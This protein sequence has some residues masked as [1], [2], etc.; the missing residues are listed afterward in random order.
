[1]SPYR[2]KI[3]KIGSLLNFHDLKKNF[4]I[5]TLNRQL[6]VWMFIVIQK[7]NFRKLLRKHDSHKTF[8]AVLEKQSLQK[9][10]KV[11]RLLFG[12][13]LFCHLY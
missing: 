1:M 13:L 11:T 10:L 12:F 9:T 5:P 6:L 4:S 8:G 3:Q 2:N 7:R